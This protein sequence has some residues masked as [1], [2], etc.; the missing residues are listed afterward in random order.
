MAD[1]WVSAY[2]STAGVTVLARSAVSRVEGRARR[3]L[4]AGLVDLDVAAAGLVADVLRRRAA[5]PVDGHGYAALRIGEVLDV[6]V[7]RQAPR[8]PVLGLPEEARRGQGRVV[9]AVPELRPVRRLVDLGAQASA[10]R[11]V[12]KGPRVGP[13]VAAAGPVGYGRVAGIATVGRGR[14]AAA[15]AS[16][17][18]TAG[19]DRGVGGR[20]IARV[21]G[22]RLRRGARA[23]RQEQDHDQAPEPPHCFESTIQRSS[24]SSPSP[25]ASPSSVDASFCRGEAA[26]CREDVASSEGNERPREGE[27]APSTR[28]TSAPRGGQAR[29]RAR[30]APPRAQRA[31]PRAERERLREGGRRPGRGTG[32]PAKGTGASAKGTGAPAKGTGAPTPGTRGRRGAMPYPARAMPG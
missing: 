10:A 27:R 24:A 1:R 12:G 32:A 13:R 28:G 19:F 5:R 25:S 30:Q 17:A 26:P 20:G 21:A 8:H 7:D 9:P 15:A 16:G 18:V 31:P 14:V 23:A 29:P 3:E 6:R 2:A 4:R 22:G 11:V